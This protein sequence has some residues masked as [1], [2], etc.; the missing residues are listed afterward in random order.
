MDLTTF[1]RRPSLKSFSDPG[2]E[3]PTPQDLR[4]VI[5]EHGL[6]HETAAGIMGVSW[7]LGAGSTTLTSWLSG[8]NPVHYASWRLLMVELGF[9]P[10]AVLDLSPEL[11]AE[12][13]RVAPAASL[14]PFNQGYQSPGPQVLGDVIKLT[15]LPQRALAAFWG[16]KCSDKGSTTIRKWKTIKGKEMR[17]MPYS[18]WRLLLINAKACAELEDE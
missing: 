7:E 17:D 9:V 1:L 13:E 11:Y 8:D 3:T 16:V 18:P 12:I 14:L 10:A 4:F 6:S 2:Y 15:K 5:D